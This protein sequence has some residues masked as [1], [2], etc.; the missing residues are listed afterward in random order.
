MLSRKCGLK[1]R[2]GNECEI[3][4]KAV[5]VWKVTLRQE[6]KLL[7][8]LLGMW[9]HGSHREDS[10]QEGDCRSD[11]AIVTVSDAENVNRSLGVL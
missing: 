3:F 10:R 4:I 7:R 2:L 6:K 5:L 9:S 1:T 11:S 8:L